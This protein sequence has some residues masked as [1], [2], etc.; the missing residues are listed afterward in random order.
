VLAAVSAIRVQVGIGASRSVVWEYLDRVRRA[1]LKF[2]QAMA[3]GRRAAGSTAVP[4][5]AAV[6]LPAAD[7]G[8]TADASRAG[9]ERR[10]ARSAL[11][12]TRAGAQGYG[13]SWVCKH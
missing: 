8:L 3:I 13:Y 10:D 6:A 2:E 5:G 12:C 11:E 4:G 1:Q 7:T 9:Q